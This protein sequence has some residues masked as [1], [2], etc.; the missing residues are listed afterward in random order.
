MPGP[1]SQTK[2]PSVLTHGPSQAALRHSLM[3]AGERGR[4][5]GLGNAGTPPPPR[6][7]TALPAAHRC[8][9]RRCPSPPW[10]SRGDRRGPPPGTHRG[11]R[12]GRSRT[13]RSSPAALEGRER[14]CGAPGAPRN[15]SA[16][17]RPRG[18]RRGGGALPGQVTPRS[19]SGH[20]QRLGAT[21]KPLPQPKE[22]S[23]AGRGNVRARGP[24]PGA[25]PGART[26]AGRTARCPEPA[27]SRGN[28]RCR[29]PRSRCGAPRGAWERAAKEEVTPRRAPPTRGG[30]GDARG[31]REGGLGGTAG[32]GRPRDA[33][34]RRGGGDAS[35]GGMETWGAA[36]R[37]GRGGG[38][39]ARGR[40]AA[41]RHPQVRRGPG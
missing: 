37:E 36:A 16:H 23:A 4:S 24:P 7:H 38:R 21:Q 13:P 9:G 35:P 27:S 5:R 3:S 26:H 14:L 39:G 6:G 11:Y 34:G 28:I 30:D 8:S 19:P 10:R 33:V 32:T 40:G 29:K 17:P 20:E 31:P 12:R 15:P 18:A 22:Q 1:H 25:I 2:P 41:R